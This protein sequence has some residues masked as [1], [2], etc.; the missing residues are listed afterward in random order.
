MAITSSGIGSNLDVDGI[1]KQLM[2]LEK[3][4]LTALDVK[5]A[6]VQSKISALGLLKG[7]ISSVQTAAGAMVPPSGTTPF[8]HFNAYRAS[9][10]DSQQGG[11]A[12]WL[13]P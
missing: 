8:D 9:V 6:G 11:G 3:K 1:V 5:E 7:V 12:F 10:A 13:R 2:A 4:P